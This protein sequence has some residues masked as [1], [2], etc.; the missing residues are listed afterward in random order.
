M[1]Y[2]EV[3]PTEFAE[4]FN[5]I[6][7]NV[8][9]FFRDQP[10]WDYLR[11]EALP[12]LLASIP[13][14]LPI[15]VWS[16]GCASG[17]EAYSIAML[18]TEM[19]GREQYIDRVKIYAT[20]IDDEALNQARQAAYGPK[21]VEGVPTPFL[22]R[23]FKT[24][25]DRLVFDKDIRRSVIFG[26]HDLMQDAPISRVHVLLC[27]NALMYFN[28]ETQSRILARFHFAMTES[29]LLFLGKAE[30]LLTHPTL[31]TPV[32]LRLRTFRKVPRDGWRDRLAVL[33]QANSDEPYGASPDGLYSATFDASPHAQLVIDDE[34][35]VAAFNERARATLSLTPSDLGRKFYELDLARRPAAV[36]A[37]LQQAIDQRRSLSL[38]DVEYLT[39]GR[40]SRY[41]D[42]QVT[43]LMDG[44]TRPTGAS[45][46]LVDV[47]RIHDLHEQLE[48]SKQDLETAYEELQ[49]T[50]EE[51]EATNEELQS[52]VEELETT[53]E[54]LQ[55][56]NEELETMNEEL[57]STNEE[58][59]TTNEQLRQRGDD[60]NGANSFLE[61]ILGGVRTGVIVVD[62]DLHV[63]AWNHRSE[64]LWGLRA[65][66][67]KGQNLL[68]LE[69]GLP[70][71]QL[72]PQIR[73]AITGDG[74]VAE[75]L[76]R[77]SIAGAVISAAVR[78]SRRST[79]WARRCAAPFW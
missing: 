57:Q 66:E 32:D 11:D 19:L 64:D 42:V 4:L 76:R 45:V 78:R 33:T 8:T 40:D 27:R 31:F 20:D 14:H 3:H 16:A 1:D 25:G 9:A 65:D 43:P 6:L 69:I 51:L 58:L 71:E 7:I 36:G 48:R 77:R 50:N 35:L 55:S 49:S 79:A 34:G 13:Q 74:S 28:T 37:L 63:I 2:L 29:A 54:E 10:A 60:L 75:V 26:R 72:R 12:P 62:R 17:E 73:S 67:V 15:R 21:A 46:S 5:A 44:A 47:T 30:M 68:N 38:N 61:S 41:F 59:Q 53:N 39:P 23:Y 22:E 24:E 52:T 18:L 70:T 56:T